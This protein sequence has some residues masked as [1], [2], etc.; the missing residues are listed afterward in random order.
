MINSVGVTSGRL[1]GS[2]ILLLYESIIRIFIFFTVS[3]FECKANKDCF[4]I[5]SFVLKYLFHRNNLSRTDLSHDKGDDDMTFG[6]RPEMTRL[7]RAVVIITPSIYHHQYHAGF[8][9]IPSYDIY[10]RRTRS[11]Q[12]PKKSAALSVFWENHLMLNIYFCN[13]YG[14]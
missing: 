3:S 7:C 6:I 2:N 5:V 14:T 4:H 1:P 13:K 12:L 8:T 11:G 10:L 9:M